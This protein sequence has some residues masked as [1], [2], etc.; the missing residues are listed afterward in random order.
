[1]EHEKVGNDNRI[2]SWIDDE[3]LEELSYN[4]RGEVIKEFPVFFGNQ[5]LIDDTVSFSTSDFKIVNGEAVYDP[6]P[7]SVK[8]MERAEAIEQA[9][10]Y[11]ASTDDA[12][13][14][15]YEQGLEHS[16]IMDEQD[17]AICALYEMMEA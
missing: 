2:M 6:L 14:E 9:P 10:D 11:M 4:D 1:M 13:C 16:A 5:Q 17:A 8:A 15:L 3:G 12:I 7:E